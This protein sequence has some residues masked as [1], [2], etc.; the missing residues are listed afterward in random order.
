MINWNGRPYRGHLRLVQDGRGF[1]VVNVIEVEDY[2]KGVLK[3][4]LI[5]PGPW[6]FSRH[7]L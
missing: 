4:R 5:L 3:M 1:T 2:L 7:R 6:K